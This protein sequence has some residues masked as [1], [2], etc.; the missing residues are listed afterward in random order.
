MYL[1][2]FNPDL[3]DI[4]TITLQKYEELSTNLIDKMRNVIV[5]ALATT[6][7]TSQDI[8]K[9]L[10]AGGG[11]RMPVVKRLLQNMFKNAEHGCEENPDEVVAVGAAYYAC[12]LKDQGSRAVN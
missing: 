12:Y 7:Y 9:V 6:N 1:G 8:H 3:D 11:C 4:L 10:L 5:E 2:D